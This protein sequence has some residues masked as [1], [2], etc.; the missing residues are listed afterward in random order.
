[1]RFCPTI[2]LDVKLIVF[3]ESVIEAVRVGDADGRETETSVINIAIGWEI[4]E[5]LMPKAYF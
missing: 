3:M 2:I 1:M 4:V 5:G